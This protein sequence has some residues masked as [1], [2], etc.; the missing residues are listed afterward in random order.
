MISC[1]AAG[2]PFHGQDAQYAGPARSYTK[3]DSSGNVLSESATS[4]AMVRDNVTGL[5]WEAKAA[6]DGVENYSNPHD[7]DNYYTWCDTNA[8]TNGGDQGYC[9]A[10]Y[11]DT[12]DFLSA[13]NDSGFGG[14]SDWRLPT[15]KELKTLVDRSRYSPSISVTYFPDTVSSY[16]WSSTTNAYSTSVAWRVDF[17]YGNDDNNNK[18]SSYYVRAV[19]G[20][21]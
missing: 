16:Y 15:I 6:A 1:P 21:Q 20:G 9:G 3:L 5:I 18:S 10:S 8:A 12:E 19:R 14:H 17:I 13:L 4:W 2:Q 11:N 7:A